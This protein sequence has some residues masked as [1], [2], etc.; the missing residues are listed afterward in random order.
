MKIIWS[1][2]AEDSL[3]NI[4]NYYRE[5]AGINV[6]RKIKS[7]IFEATEQLIKYPDSGQVEE[8][9]KQLKE[10]HRYLARRHLKIIYKQVEDG[11]L[12]TD[13]FDTRQ[14][15]IKLNNPKCND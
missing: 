5:V 8:V 15:P 12:I 1:N 4:Y 13:V 10:D 9:L 7:D 6:A 2:F 11:I 14:D 3:I